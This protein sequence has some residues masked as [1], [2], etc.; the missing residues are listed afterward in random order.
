MDIKA[1]LARPV[2]AQPKKSRSKA[3]R[4][5][6]TTDAGQR[7]EWLHL[8][9][10]E[11]ICTLILDWNERCKSTRFSCDFVISVRDYIHEHG[12][13]TEAQRRALH[14][15]VLRWNMPVP[16]TPPLSELLAYL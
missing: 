11:Q 10:G 4:D 2:P 15:I 16:T 6:W 5:G 8:A 3:V 7:L 1:M 13:V 12:R 9:S 14:N